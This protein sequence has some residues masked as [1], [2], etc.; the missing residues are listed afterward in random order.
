MDWKAGHQFKECDFYAG[1][2]GDETYGLDSTTF[3]ILLRLVLKCKFEPDF[4]EKVFD[5]FDG[6]KM[7]L[8]SLMAHVQNIPGEMRS[9][10]ERMAGKLIALG[11]IRSELELM[12]RFSQIYVN[13]FEIDITG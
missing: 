4:T 8:D 10:L 5:W 9:K 6:R 11:F 7:R 3:G 2:D 12:T 1:D 13:A